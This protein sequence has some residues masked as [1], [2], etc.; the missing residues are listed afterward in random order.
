MVDHELDV[1]RV[2]RVAPPGHLRRLIQRSHAVSVGPDYRGDR[3]DLLV[4]VHARKRQKAIEDYRA[5]V[6]GGRVI[7]LLAFWVRELRIV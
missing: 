2:G 5:H 7:G 4:A 6:P 1:R 3:C